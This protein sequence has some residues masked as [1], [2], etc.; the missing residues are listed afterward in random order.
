MEQEKYIWFFEWL[1]EA[2]PHNSSDTPAVR[3]SSNEVRAV[4]GC[5]Q[6]I[7]RPSPDRPYIV[8]GIICIISNCA[9]FSTHTCFS[10]T[11][12][13]CIVNEIRLNF[14]EPSGI[15]STDVLNR[16]I[17][18]LGAKAKVKKTSPSPKKATAKSLRRKSKLPE[19]VSTPKASKV[20]ALKTSKFAS[21]KC[22]EV[23]DPLSGFVFVC[24]QSAPINTKARRVE[25]T[26][27]TEE[28]TKTQVSLTH[29]YYDLK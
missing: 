8:R 20:S 23:D 26:E 7:L 11:L 3:P 16:P 5:T 14:P 12:P 15:Y 10:C 9:Y 19:K 2:T 13:H 25:I 4:G 17:T 27:K 6:N 24:S 28:T 1:P 21:N 18:K 29:I 22:A